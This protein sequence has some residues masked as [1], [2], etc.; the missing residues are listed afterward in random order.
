MSKIIRLTESEFKKFRPISGSVVIKGEQNTNE[1]TVGGQK[2]F[3]DS[4]FTPEDNQV[5]I[6]RVIKVPDEDYVDTNIR[7]E[8]LLSVD[9][10][11]WVN[12]FSVMQ[13]E[14][15]EVVMDQPAGNL[16]ITKIEKY[17]VVPYRQC[18]M[19]LT[20][21]EDG[22]QYEM[23]NDFILLTPQERFDDGLLTPDPVRR[24]VSHRWYTVD[25]APLYGSFRYLQ[26]KYESIQVKPG[27]IVF[28]LDANQF[29]LEHAP[30]YVYDKRP[31]YVTRVHKVLAVVDQVDEEADV[32]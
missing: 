13:A 20:E 21:G 23:L 22:P 28:M 30:H 17:S 6:N 8:I 31:H 19:L 16:L 7:S 14:Q 1:I 32:F 18:F 10:L 25:R 26:D 11:V 3:Y 27:D 2:L 9:D 15:I 5:V 4:S 12:Y 29:K 24:K